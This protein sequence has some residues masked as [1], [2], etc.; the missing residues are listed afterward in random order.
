M[1][2]F[3]IIQICGWSFCKHIACSNDEY[4]QWRVSPDAPIAFQEFMIF[5]VKGNLFTHAMQMELRFFT[6]LKKSYMIEVCTAVGD[7]GGFILILAE[8]KTP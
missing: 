7:E 4:H 6:V 2:G 8:R 3:A 1:N 5:P